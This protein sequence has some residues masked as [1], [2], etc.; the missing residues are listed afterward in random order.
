MKKLISFALVL[1]LVFSMTACGCDHE[2]GE[3]Q[4]KS[5][6]STDLTMERVQSCTKCEKQL[7]TETSPVGI[8]PANGVMPIGPAAWF[9]CLTTN[10]K[11]YDTSGMLVPMAVESEDGALLRSIVSPTGF[12]S[13]ISF[14]DKDDNVITNEQSADHGAV[15]RIRIEAQFDNSTATT[16]YTLLMLMAMTNNS[17]WENESLNA[18]AKGIMGGESLTDNGYTYTMQIVSPETHTVVVHIEA[19]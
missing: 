16:F 14:F 10:I 7:N 9:E 13:V 12:K 8:T 1:A 6:N 4:V 5:V 3:F 15:H 19:E 11:T 18:L 17:G 2:A